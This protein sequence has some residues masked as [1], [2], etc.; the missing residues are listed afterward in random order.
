MKIKVGIVGYGNLGKAIESELL[1]N[2][3]FKLIAIFSRRTVTSKCG[4]NVEPFCDIL[5]FKGKID[6]MFMCGGS[7]EDIETQ[8]PETAAAFSTINCF[9]THSKIKRFTAEMN[10]ICKLNHTVSLMACG[11]DPG[12]FSIIR[13]LMYSL[14][15]EIPVT[16]WGKGISMGHSDAIRKVDGVIDGVQFTVPSKAAISHARTDTLND[17][18]LHY[19]ECYVL[20]NKNKE[21][22]IEEK[23]KSIPNYFLNQ[24]TFVNFVDIN[25]LSDLKSK[26]SHKGMILSNIR[27]SQ[28]KKATLEFKAK[29]DSNAMFTAIVMVRYSL[30]VI[31]YLSEEK[32]G[33][34]L[35]IDIP[36]SKLLTAKELGFAIKNL[37]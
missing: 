2:K 28:T 24:P 6:I 31:N 30:A 14:S 23:I 18:P 37:C 33:A 27:L 29:M 4:T 8:L 11:W 22:E 34:Y 32:F 13:T 19:R 35:P 10:K 17:E 25:K 21:T 5:K 1:K 20:A 26:Q 9:D 7:A 12:I 3:K 36:I 16:F 15:G